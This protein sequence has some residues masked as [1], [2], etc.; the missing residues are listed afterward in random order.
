VQAA[1]NLC[2]ENAAVESLIQGEEHGQSEFRSA[3]EDNEVMPTCKEMIRS[4]LLP[5]VNEHVLAL[6]AL[7]KTV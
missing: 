3:I 2:G 4:D 5:R 1:A 7:Q 6:N